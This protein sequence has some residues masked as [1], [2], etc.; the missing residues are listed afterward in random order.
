[1]KTMQVEK[2]LDNFGR[3][4]TVWMYACSRCG[5]CVDV[6]PVYNETADKYTAPGF[7]IKKMRGL[8]TNKLLPFGGKPSV[9]GA[10]KIAKGLYE[11]T[12]CGR[13]WSVCPYNYDLVGLWEK[14]RESAFET[15]L[16]LEPLQQMVDALNA[17]KNIFK[18]PHAR[19]TEWAKGLD[20]PIK[21]EADTIF[22]VGCL[23]SYRGPLKNAAKATAAILN[24]AGENWTILKD[25]VCCGAP[26]KFSGGIR[27]Q[28]QLM[29]TN[30][31]AI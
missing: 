26:L 9:D 4:E 24:A 3:S 17:E 12:L 20:I 11:C 22:F 10:K 8:I 27:Y 29:E 25:E 1:M 2:F 7:K 13:C 28:E 30:I 19:R 23:L 6:C 18:R 21:E 31:R 5:E 15:G 14:C 16:A